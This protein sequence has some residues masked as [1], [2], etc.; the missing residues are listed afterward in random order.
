MS[1]QTKP[2]MLAEKKEHKVD[3]TEKKETNFQNWVRRKGSLEKIEAKWGNGVPLS[4]I[5]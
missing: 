4:K 3:S 2:P 5:H 1:G